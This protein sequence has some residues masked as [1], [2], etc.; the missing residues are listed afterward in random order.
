MSLKEIAVRTST[1]TGNEK[2]TEIFCDVQRVDASTQTEYLYTGDDCIYIQPMLPMEANA[3]SHPYQNEKHERPFDKS[4]PEATVEPTVNHIY[5][6]VSCSEQ[7][8]PPPPN[9]IGKRIKRSYKCD[10]CDK[11]LS[12]ASSFVQH[13]TIHSGERPYQCEYCLRTFRQVGNLAS[14]KRT[15]IGVKPYKCDVC[16]K[17]F[18]NSSNVVVHKRTHTGEKP[19][20]CDICHKMFSQFAHLVSHKRTHTG[21][22]PFQCDICQ[23]RFNNPSNLT[24]H[25]R[26]HGGERPYKCD[27]C[28]KT[29]KQSGHLS[30]HRKSHSREQPLADVRIAEIVTPLL[31]EQ[32]SGKVVTIKQEK[33]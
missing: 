18:S 30:S 21:E 11:S 22:A 32:C 8:N 4:Q 16:D 31:A 5:C 19:F 1:A 17:R 10:V 9:D 14:H 13:K 3:G 25:K 29:F 2:C 7:E 15:H 20:E 12:S 26:I 27:I 28:H 24:T 33:Q 23:K 6:T